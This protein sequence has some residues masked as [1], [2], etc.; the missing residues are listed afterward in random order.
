MPPEYGE[1][2]ELPDELESQCSG[3][4][5]D[6]SDWSSLNN[7]TNSMDASLIIKGP[8]TSDL[9]GREEK[10]ALVP[11]LFPR[12]P[13]TLY[14]GTAKENVELLPV[15]QRKLL[16]WKMSSVTPC[17]VKDTLIRSHFKASKKSHDWLG[18]WGQHL[19]SRGFRTIREHQKLNHFPGSFQIGRKDR[20]WHN[21]SKMQ[22][23]FGK[24][25]FNFFP[26][27]FVLPHD[28][29]QLRE[30]WDKG[31]G[32]RR[33]IVK[34]PASARGIGIQVIHKWSQIPKRRPLLVQRYI[35]RP[36]LIGGNKFDLRIYVYISSYDPLHIYIYSDGLVRF[37]SCKYSSSVKTLRNKFMHLTNYSVNKKNSEYQSNSDDKACQGHKWSL[38]ALWQYLGAR[39]VNTI[40][41]WE[42][43]K[44][45]IIKTIIASEPYINTLVKMYVRS[46]NNCHELFGFDIMLDEK[47]KPWLLEVNISPSLH[48]NTALDFSIKGQMIRD[49]L[50][51]AGFVLP[52]HEDAA[53]AGSC[54]TSSST[55]SVSGG[56]R[57]R[58]KIST[59][60]IL[61]DRLKRAHFT[62]QRNVNQTFLST[63]LSVLTPN[64]VRVLTQAEDELS[65]RGDFERAFPSSTSGRYLRFFEQ[66]RYLNILLSQWEL[67]YW[68]NRS[69]GIDLLR[70]LCQKGVHLGSSC[71]SEHLWSSMSTLSIKSGSQTNL[72][73]K[74]EPIRSSPSLLQ[75]LLL[76]PLPP[77][78]PVL[79][80]PAPSPAPD[81]DRAALRDT[82][83]DYE[84][85]HTGFRRRCKERRT[86]GQMEPGRCHTLTNMQQ[87]A[88]SVSLPA[89]PEPDAEI[90]MNFMR[91]HCCYDTIPTSSKLVIFDTTLQVKKAFF[92]LVAN[93]LRAATLWDS[94]RQCFVGMLTITDFIN[95]LHRYYKSPMVQIYE[96]EEHKIETW[97]E[98]YLQYSLNRLIS[99]TPDSS[100]FDAVYA[101]LKHKIH[102]LPVIDPESG[103][104][105]HIMTHKRI[106]KFLKIFGSNIPKPRFLQKKIS[107][108][109]IGTFQ[110]IAMVQETAT[111]YDALSIFVA[112]RVSALPVVNEQG[113]VVALY[114]RFDV[115]NL[116]AQKNYNN[117]NM[118][119]R[120]ALQRRVCCV[121]GVIKC[122]PHETL[123]TV[124]D[125]I[126]EAEVHR[127]VLVDTDD[128]VRGIVSLSDLLQALVLTPAEI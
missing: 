46:P 5:E 18:C 11:S 85:A 75:H 43:I 99:I 32:R 105:L 88:A 104:V 53:P 23:R 52:R 121:E 4:E 78:G 6:E 57:D 96:L 118:S 98:V 127:L 66:R 1:E 122:Y 54:S 41:I 74:E 67:K 94:K 76:P 87:D 92:A 37:A 124:I 77:A 48:T 123:E 39:G 128:V 93:G 73:L 97:R 106:L 58:S 90:Y 82:D 13:P 14:F 86:N 9:R 91:S 69:K 61:D 40:L 100:L 35:H 7:S 80:M 62:G 12:N 72:S 126:A 22:A 84:P 63:V 111:V 49:L 71:S 17:V 102:R 64:D 89:A 81:L 30:A 24:K 38:K 36:Y 116:A 101:L 16:K 10:P 120:E 115:I 34:P 70:S 31:R 109:A 25:E 27:S 108:A 20:L 15:E 112:R 8:V 113:K 19:K 110:K 51:L 33:W 95:I 60:H 45:I 56:E 50:N 29:R 117:L 2:E 68:N 119:M 59:E 42:K 28:V 107:E 21:L 55:S 125:R 114:S 83:L 65:R 79:R 44:D 47:L 26:R 3:D 103:N